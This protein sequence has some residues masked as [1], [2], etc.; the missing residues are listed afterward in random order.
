MIGNELILQPDQMH[1]FPQWVSLAPFAFPSQRNSWTSLEKGQ[2]ESYSALGV[3]AE[4]AKALGMPEFLL[5][6]RYY[7]P[8]QSL[9]TV[10]EFSE[11]NPSCVQY[12]AHLKRYAAENKITVTGDPVCRT[13]LSMNKKEDYRR[14]RQIWLP[15]ADVQS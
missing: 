12:L 9:Y 14:F 13:F 10:V 1:I 6:G 15:I 7:P 3:M 5:E 11:K 2:D 8:V 4:D